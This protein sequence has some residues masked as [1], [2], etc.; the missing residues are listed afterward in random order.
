MTSLAAAWRWGILLVLGQ[1]AAL[2][3]AEAGPR[4][5]YQHLRAPA[6]AI[7]WAALALLVLQAVI[8]GRALAP[9]VGI[10][11]AWVRD[12]VP[13]AARWV[14]VAAFIATSAVA[15][16]EPVMWAAELLATTAL[17]AVALGNI[18]LLGF[19]WPAGKHRAVSA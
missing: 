13:V 8:V 11:R 4:V 6:S 14:L 15:S 2:V 12:Q 9:R 18:I 10:I 3:L 17:Q 7:G 16:K 1:A 5:S 19:S